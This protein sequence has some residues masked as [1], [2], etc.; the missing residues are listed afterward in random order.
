MNQSTRLRQQL[1]AIGRALTPQA[2]AASEALWADAA[3]HALPPGTQVLRD[4]AYGAHE[5][6]RLDLFLPPASAHG[7]PPAV[8]L[9]VH[10]GGFTGGDKHR[11]GSHLYDNVARWAM[12]QGMAGIQINYRLAP[13]HGWPS[14]ADDI[15]RAIDWL[16]VHAERLGIDATRTILAGHSAGAAHVASYI[17]GH[18]QHGADRQPLRGVVLLSGIY[19]IPA[20]S[21]RPSVQSYYG[22]DPD[23]HALQSSVDGLTACELPLLLTVAEHD[24]DEFHAQAMAL[25]A[26]TTAR[27]GRMP[28]FCIVPGHNHFTQVF[29]L[30]CGDPHASPLSQ[31]LA[32]FVQPLLG[33]A[34]HVQDRP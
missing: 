30:G 31:F 13:T 8:F 6:H 29:H 23:A 20:M 10:G 24:P 28:A 5:R 26:R 15:G 12:S 33:N 4:L 27:R 19:D 22:S 34:A 16:A 3:R 21:Q 18:G 1:L 14:A 7:S 11:A 2:V 17:A 9:F 32:A 25:L